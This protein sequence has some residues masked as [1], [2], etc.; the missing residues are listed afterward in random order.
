M[1]PVRAAA[2][3]ST[4]MLWSLNDLYVWIKCHGK[5][6]ISAYPLPSRST[7]NAPQNFP[8]V[9]YFSLKNG[10]YTVSSHE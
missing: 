7:L 6:D 2:V 5:S 1:T 8:V 4:E 10:I 9:T 3:R